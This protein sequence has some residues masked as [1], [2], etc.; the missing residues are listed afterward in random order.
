MLATLGVLG[1][2]IY[3]STGGMH[4]GGFDNRHFV[5]LDTSQVKAAGESAMGLPDSRDG[6]KLKD[7]FVL[8]LWN[9]CSGVKTGTRID[10]NF[11]SKAWGR[12]LFDQHENWSLL[13]FDITQGALKNKDLNRILDSTGDAGRKVDD[14]ANDIN[15]KLNK[16]KDDLVKGG[17]KAITF[18]PKTILA[19]YAT[20]MALVILQIILG[21]ASLKTRAASVCV[22]IFSLLST[23][24]LAAGAGMAQVLYS[25]LSNG[26]NK[27]TLPDGQGRF[28]AST[29]KH[30]FA[31]SWVAVVLSLGATVCWMFTICCGSTADKREKKGNPH[32]LGTK[33][34]MIGGGTKYERL[35]P[36]GYPVQSVEQAHYP[37]GQMG[38]QEQGYAQQYYNP[39]TQPGGGRY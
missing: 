7:V 37:G 33:L 4:K 31:L 21:F 22:A 28:S 11:C 19:L 20:T 29:G 36:A 5:L 30:V 25:S 10:L 8:N 32:A 14:T 3:I 6:N 1:I 27:L 12:E 18:L 9:Y 38:M 13:G 17:S 16:A 15:G 23:L 39:S 26:L 2:L 24:I 34:G 35:E